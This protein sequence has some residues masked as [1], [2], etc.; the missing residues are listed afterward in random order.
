MVGSQDDFAEEGLLEYRG[1]ESRAG[2]DLEKGPQVQPS[3]RPVE[4]AAPRMRKITRPRI[5]AV[6]F[7]I[8]LTLFC[9]ESR[10]TCHSIPGSWFACPDVFY[11]NEG[12]GF[13]K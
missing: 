7:C 4:G 11:E 13:W 3:A 9:V 2:L 6:W 12:R 10:T 8:L 1:L 5:R